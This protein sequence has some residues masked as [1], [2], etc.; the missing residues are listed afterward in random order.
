M[1]LRTIGQCDLYHREC[2]LGFLGKRNEIQKRQTRLVAA[3][4]WLSC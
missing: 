4:I 2:F 1:A 3:F